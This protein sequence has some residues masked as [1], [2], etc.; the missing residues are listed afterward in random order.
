MKK[1]VFCF[2]FLFLIWELEAQDNLPSFGKVD[3]AD[4]AMND[5]SFDPG[6]EAIVLLDVGEIEFN[7]FEN[8]G[9][10]S[11]SSY[12]IRI[13]IL[14]EKAVNR[15]E[16]KLSYYAKNKR[17][18]ISNI[19]GVSY[20]LDANGKIEESKLEGRNIYDKV[21]DKEFSEIS[22]A[23]PNVKTGTVFEYRYKTTR[24]S[25][26]YL[27]S[28]KFQ[29]NIP[30]IYS[31]YKVTIPEYFQFTILVTKR[32]EIE[33]KA[34]TGIREGMWYI[35]HNIKGLKDEPYS[36]GRID[37]VQRLD[38]QLSNI[39]SPGYSEDFRTTWPKII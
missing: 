26:S 34:S 8:V 16:I 4:L 23:L 21:I 2:L 20:N 10:V 25:Y 36:S 37:Y 33:K 14:K 11:E 9:W 19:S 1:I 28:W 22:F 27:P 17:E 6:A 13:K 39:N 5:C 7:Y 18:N 32:Q 30:V 15:A 3:K 35:M 31:A 38:F 24:K 29:N 12:R